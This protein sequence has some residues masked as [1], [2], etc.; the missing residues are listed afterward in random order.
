MRTVTEQL[1]QKQ[2]SDARPPSF[3]FSHF[4]KS[5]L[6]TFVP[7]FVAME[8]TIP[9][10]SSPLSGGISHSRSIPENSAG[11]LQGQ[12]STTRQSSSCFG[13]GQITIALW[14][15]QTPQDCVEER[16][17]TGVWEVSGPESK[18]AHECLRWPRPALLR[19][20]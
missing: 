15:S 13:S 9:P 20:R 17:S 6:F 7:S 8:G 5:F 14:I 3:V 10:A 11:S 12:S 4:L 18:P 19:L 2:S 1:T 16:G